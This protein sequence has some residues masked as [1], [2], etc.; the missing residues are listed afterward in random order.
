MERADVYLLGTGLPSFWSVAM[1]PMRLLL[2]LSGWTA[3]DWTSAAAIEQLAPPANPDPQV[4]AS[5]CQAFHTSPSLS[6]DR[7]RE[8]TGGE[9]A[10]LAV[11][12]NRLA[13]LG[14]VIHDLQGGVYRWRQILPVTLSSELIG[15]EHPET[16]AAKRLVA[17][18]RVRVQRDESQPDGLRHIEGRV[19]STEVSLGLD[20][21][22]RMVRG[23]C[24]CLY[25]YKG[26]LRRGPCR[27]LQA[28]RDQAM[29]A[30][31]AKPDAASWFA[32]L[33]SGNSR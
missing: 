3:N 30:A 4:V 29:A 2:G 23:R 5:V 20:A 24:S 7:I 15:P 31:E 12:L 13:M 25:H 32:S 19:D 33:W 14:Q 28:L 26:G 10:E 17:D 16:A 18:R 8:T 1:G 22:G 21:D 6:F 27:H 11:S 9:P